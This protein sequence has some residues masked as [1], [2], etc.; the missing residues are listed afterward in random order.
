MTHDLFRP[1]QE[2][3]MYD[4]M[5]DGT[6]GVEIEC[7][8]ADLPSRIAE[9]TVHREGSLR[10]EANEYVTNGAVT[11]DRLNVCMDRLTEAMIAN[12]SHV[13]EG[14][15]RASTHIHY[16]MQRRSTHD[17]V[18]AII[19]LTLVEPILLRLCGPNRDGNLFCIPSYDCGDLPQYLYETF[20]YMRRTG[21]YYFRHARGKY[22]SLNLDPI[23]SFG[24]IEYRVFPCSI[25]KD[26]ILQ[27]AGWVDRISNLHV[28]EGVQD[29]AHRAFIFNANKQPR[30]FLNSVFGAEC[31]EPFSDYELYSALRVGVANAYECSKVYQEF[32]ESLNLMEKAA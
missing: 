9:W 17:V 27:W 11:I 16:N 10:G 5:Q 7:E 4:Q 31:I 22:A 24:T 19:G 13:N 1:L 25:Q 14:S 3:I 15:H 28:Q 20:T 12:G 21:R 2:I 30:E 23:T 18:G 6:F 26:K 32:L 29:L 8:G